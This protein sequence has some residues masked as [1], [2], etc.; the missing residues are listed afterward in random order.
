MGFV[1]WTHHLHSAAPSPYFCHHH[2]EMM[3]NYAVLIQR[4]LRLLAR[5]SPPERQA[6]L[7]KYLTPTPQ[8]CLHPPIMLSLPR[9]DPELLVPN[10]A[11]KSSTLCHRVRL[12]KLPAEPS[13]TNA[14]PEMPLRLQLTERPSPEMPQSLSDTTLDTGACRYQRLRAPRSAIFS[15]LYLSL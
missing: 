1:H 10:P 2:P 13:L 11:S 9:N 15:C 5:P 4:R 7:Y 3:P 14:L 12:A 8:N 6:F